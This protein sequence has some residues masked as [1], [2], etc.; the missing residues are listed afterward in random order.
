MNLRQIRR[1]IGTVSGSSLQW[2]IEQIRSC[3]GIACDLPTFLFEESE[4]VH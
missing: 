4:A 3:I 1:C 2:L